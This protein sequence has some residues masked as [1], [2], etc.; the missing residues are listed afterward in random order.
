MILLI[1]LH[2]RQASNAERGWDDCAMPAR[3]M[4]SYILHLPG[5]TRSLFGPLCPIFG[6]LRLAKIL[7]SE[8]QKSL[9]LTKFF[10]EALVL[11]IRDEP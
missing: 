6:Q 11:E 7:R 3:N 9:N 10:E 4:C 2:L 5:A 1:S 8:V